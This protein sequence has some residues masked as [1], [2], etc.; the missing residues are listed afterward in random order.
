[1]IDILMINSL[2][3]DGISKFLASVFDVKNKAIRVCS[4]DAFSEIGESDFTGIDCLCVYSVIEGDVS[5]LLQLY[6]YKLNDTEI[7]NALCRACEK[8]HLACYVS[9]DEYENWLLIDANGQIDI[10]KLLELQ[11]EKV[12]KFLRVSSA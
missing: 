4:L 9:K 2:S 11:D 7:I 10:V 6:R 5:Q 12:S 1:M 8:H 3:E